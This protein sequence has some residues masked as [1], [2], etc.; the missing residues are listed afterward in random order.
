M[1][2]AV[3]AGY[4]ATPSKGT[5]MASSVRA[6][7]FALCTVLAVPGAVHAQAAK[8]TLSKECH[9][10]QSATTAEKPDVIPREMLKDWQTALPCLAQIIGTF[11]PN[12]SKPD[13]IIGRNDYLRAA[14]AARLILEENSAPAI[15][16]FR[17]SDNLDV[18]SVLTFGARSTDFNFRL[19]STLI[20]GNVIDNTS[21]CVPL[22]HLFASDLSPNGRANLLAVTSVVIPWAIAE[23][24]KNIQ[25]ALADLRPHV[26][27]DAVDTLRI[28]ATMDGKV[29]ARKVTLEREGAAPQNAGELAQCRAYKLLWGT[30]KLQY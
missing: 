5:A 8:P 4:R 14:K 18:I 16:L 20:L 21:V 17:R 19:N 29:A 26:A 22:D 15:E 7:A 24:L 28:L 27:A 11:R 2:S 12:I 23:N 13:D 10:L 9:V 3:D 25:A 6:L 30:G 1:I